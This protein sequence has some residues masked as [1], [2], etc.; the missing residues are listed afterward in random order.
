MGRQS[1]IKQLPPEL[2]EQ[3]DGLLKA[4]VTLESIAAK[5]AE[6]GAPVSRSALGRYKLELDAV[7]DRL[8]R[9]REISAAFAEKLG[10]FADDRQG[11]MLTELLQTVIFDKLVPQDSDEPPSFDTQEIF[12]LCAAVKDLTATQKISADREMRIRA[13]ER[14]LAREQAAEAAAG[15]AKAKGLSAD[16][17]AF[18][19]AQ[20]LGIGA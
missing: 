5:L 19:R 20:V 4:G 3:V 13:Q 2:R 18:I 6:L 14:Q 10:A 7:G 11:R 15:A 16:T 8:R 1:S 12:R 17:A 9:S